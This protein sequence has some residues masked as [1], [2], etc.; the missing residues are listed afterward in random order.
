MPFI[1]PPV[2]ELPTIVYYGPAMAGKTTNFLALQRLLSPNVRSSLQSHAREVYRTLSMEVTVAD[3]IQTTPTTYYLTT[4]PGCML[5][6]RAR[7]QLLHRAVGVV[8]VFDSHPL[9]LA[10]NLNTLRELVDVLKQQKRSLATFPIVLQ[11]NKRD[12]PEPLSREQL[13]TYL[14]PRQWPVVEAIATRDYGIMD[15]FEHIIALVTK[16]GTPN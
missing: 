16:Y 2:S 15:T 5:Y 12:L 11:Y 13:D 1:P 9:K 4:T 7:T 10:E 14:N 8:C 3:S 6:T